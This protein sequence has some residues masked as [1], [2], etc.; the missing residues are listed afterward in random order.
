M[1]E[2]PNITAAL[3]LWTANQQFIDVVVTDYQF[4]EPQTG[5][6]LVTC[7]QG[8]RPGTPCFVISGTWSKEKCPK[9]EPARHLYYRAKPFDAHELVAAMKLLPPDTA[10]SEATRSSALPTDWRSL[11]NSPPKFR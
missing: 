1:L 8:S 9:D 2:A 10:T 7:V 6:D 3:K 4:N 5:L 11:A